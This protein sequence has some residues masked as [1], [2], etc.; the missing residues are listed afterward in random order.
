[1]A[2]PATIAMSSDFFSAFAHIPARQQRR[3][4]NMISK[5]EWN[6]TS[7]GKG[8]SVVPIESKGDD[9]QAGGVTVATM[10]RLKGLEFE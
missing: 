1:M 4:P 10:H 7:S 3:D 5:F 8:M 6:P 9:R 2:N